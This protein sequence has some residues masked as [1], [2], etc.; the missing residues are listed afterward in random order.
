MLKSLNVTNFALIENASIEFFPGL[1][2]LTGET[3][4]GKSII[5]DAL[6]AALGYRA[7]VDA[8]RTG[9]DFFRVEAV[10]DISNIP[11][12]QQM[13][14]EQGITPEEDGTIIINRRL[15]K[16]GKNT[17]VVNGCQV[18][19]SVLRHLGDKLVDMHGQHESHILMRPETHL[20]LVDS[21]NK[22]I[23]EELDRYRRIWRIWNET[24]A[25]IE[26]IS[27]S[28]RERE[29]RIDM[30]K[31]QTQEI[32]A[33]SLKMQEDGKLEA[34]V[35]VLA[36]SEKI[37]KSVNTAYGL[38]N[39]GSKGATA[40]ISTLAEVRRELEIASRYDV[41]LQGYATI[42]TD[43]LYQLEDAALELRDY[44]D[45]FEYNPN[46]LAQ[47]QERL[48]VIDKLKRKYGSTIEEILA[49]YD[50]A[51]AELSSISNYD[52]RL[53]DLAEQ[54]NRQEKELASSAV[55]LDALRQKAGKALSSAISRH[56]ADLG[57]SK[58]TLEFK[59]TTT[60]D[61]TPNGKNQTCIVFSANP[62]EELKP[63]HKV[64]SGGE[65]S[66]VALAIKTVCADQD[67]TGVMVFDEVDTGIG[68]QTAQMVAEKISFIALSKQVLCITHLPQMA[69][70]ADRHIHI[71]KQ[72]E[73]DRTYTLISE[74]AEE[75]RV[76]EVT[77]MITG[78]DI[79]E[80]SLENTSQILKTAQG[81]KEKWKNKA[82]A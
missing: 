50:H 9:C 18:T 28:A 78:S 40:V 27:N 80:L 64:A 23:L 62:G 15:S 25:E 55:R 72:V 24:K 54:K 5:I 79:T 30:L 67:D 16:T 63:L 60:E 47:L 76:L 22:D 8:I 39:H 59:I 51:S 68:G 41:K 69:V 46:R 26:Y 38:L 1:N 3:G 73:G 31:W 29:Q 6:S 2:V 35:R 43:V 11:S 57:L 14:D 21:Y 56:L 58:A 37:A 52:Q 12:A 4:A 65:L 45:S 7:S 70:M 44:C 42:V 53:N 36:N 49:Y 61:F 82:Q 32:A 77:R 20:G 81:K 71:S 34:E 74:L 66:R 75:E 19:S 10:F 17:I 13:L 33:A 48:D